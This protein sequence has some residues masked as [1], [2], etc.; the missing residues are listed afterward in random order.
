ML[1]RPPGFHRTDT[2]LPEATRFRAGRGSMG[3]LRCG[4]GGIPAAVVSWGIAAQAEISTEWP[5]LPPTGSGPLASPALTEADSVASL[6][7]SPSLSP[8]A[9]LADWREARAA[10]EPEVDRKSTRLNSSH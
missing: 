6:S 10:A 5:T 2:L 8:P 7:L 9:G 4:I 3:R 1:R